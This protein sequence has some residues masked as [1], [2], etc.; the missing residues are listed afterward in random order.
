MHQLTDGLMGVIAQPD[1][2]M[3]VWTATTATEQNGLVSAGG[4]FYLTK[5][6]HN[7]AIGDRSI[8]LPMS[9]IPELLAIL[10]KIEEQTA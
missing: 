3:E 6:H 5:K 2:R 8:G 9:D 4:Y 7:G 10:G 1:Y